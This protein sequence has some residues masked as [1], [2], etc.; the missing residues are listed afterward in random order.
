MGVPEKSKKCFSP[1]P[2]S[3]G[4]FQF[5]Q[6]WGTVSSA[7]APHVDFFEKC[8]SLGSECPPTLAAKNGG[9]CPPPHF[10]GGGALIKSP[11]QA[12]IFLQ[13]SG[14]TVRGTKSGEAPKNPKWGGTFQKS[15]KVCVGGAIK[16]S[17][18]TAWTEIYPW[19]YFYS[20]TESSN[21]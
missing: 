19:P 7:R 9:Q 10:V 3:R 8:P 5:R 11:P 15:P 14:E 6:W 20:N 21:L 13:K 2:P 4:I 16:K 17:L 18:P 1:P 12:S